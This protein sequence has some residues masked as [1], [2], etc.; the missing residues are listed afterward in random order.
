M[1]LLATPIGVWCSCGADSNA[2]GKRRKARAL[3]NLADCGAVLE[4]GV[5]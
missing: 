2:R 4:R 5:L 1:K 3:Q